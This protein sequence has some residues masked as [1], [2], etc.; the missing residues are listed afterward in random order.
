MV[1]L[2][3]DGGA[4]ESDPLSG[5]HLHVGRPVELDLDHVRGQELSLQDVELHVPDEERENLLVFMHIVKGCVIPG[6]S[7]NL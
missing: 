1:L 7:R 6:Q 5:E 4:G 2:W 3:L